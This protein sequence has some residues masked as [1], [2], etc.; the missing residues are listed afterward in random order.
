VRRG[1]IIIDRSEPKIAKQ[2]PE[3]IEQLAQHRRCERGHFH[4]G[5]ECSTR[6]MPIIPIDEDFAVCPK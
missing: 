5:D 1:K 3:V 4:V 6:L 2:V